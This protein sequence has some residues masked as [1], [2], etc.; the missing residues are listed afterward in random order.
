VGAAAP[1]IEYRRASPDDAAALVR[2]MSD[3]QVFGGLLQTPYPG[4]EAWRKNLEQQADQNDGVHLLAI[5]DDKLIASGRIHS[6]GTRMRRRHV[7]GLGICVASDRQNQG[8]G[9]EMMRRLLEWSDNWAGYLRI[10]LN[11]Y[12]D[13]ERAIALYRRFGFEM[14]GTHRAH[15][16]RDGVYVDTHTM[17]RFHP[18]PPQVPRPIQQAAQ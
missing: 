7:A 18:K 9:F 11:V 15:A 6:V 2:L 13:N 12:T 10:E 4:V 1:V 5:D 14:E 8:V 17:A 16:L 3:P